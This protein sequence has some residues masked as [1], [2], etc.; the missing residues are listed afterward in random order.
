[1]R[2]AYPADKLMDAARRHDLAWCRRAMARC[3]ETDLAMKS[4]TGADARD[5]LISLVLELAAGVR[6]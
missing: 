3:A 4:V 5:R 6:P 1:M 2:P